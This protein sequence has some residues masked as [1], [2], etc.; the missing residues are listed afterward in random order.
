MAEKSHIFIRVYLG[1]LAVAHYCSWWSALCLFLLS[2]NRKP[3]IAG[4]DVLTNRESVCAA[5]H[6]R[7]SDERLQA[8]L[9]Y[10]RDLHWAL[11]PLG[12]DKRP[13]F[14]LLPTDPKTGKRTWKPYAKKRAGIGEIQRWFREGPD[15]NIG[16]ITGKV[17]GG[18]IIADFDAEPPEGLHMPVT[19][20]VVTARGFHAYFHYKRRLAGFKTAWGEVLGDGQ[21]AVLPPSFVKSKHCPDGHQYY[22]HEGLSPS[23]TEIA[24]LPLTYL[25]LQDTPATD[26]QVDR[27]SHHEAV[28]YT[29]E[30]SKKE[31]CYFLASSDGVSYQGNELGRACSSDECLRV[32]CPKLGI[33]DRAFEQIGSG[34]RCVL[35]GHEEKHPS[36]SLYRRAD[37]IV[38]YRDWHSPVK[39]Q[40]YYLPEVRASQAYRRATKLE[41]FEL[42]VWGLRLLWEA[43]MVTPARLPAHTVPTNLRPTVK[44]VYD[45]FLV[46]LGLRWLHTPGMA[47]P[48][49]WRFASAW[50]GVGERQVGK[51]IPELLRLKLI[52]VAGSHGS[53]HRKVTLFLLGDP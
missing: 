52:R 37:G 40:W 41:S 3:E 51:A 45:G 24:L 14:A 25:Q 27:E 48:F 29:P 16:V 21:Y 44:K 20:R 30:G 38:V 17:S 23:D 50:C 31:I 10:A 34:F 26:G 33:P 53:G 35:P 43:G 5:S 28:H 7:S 19:P 36:A 4:G 49:A 18:L 11:I 32:V 2:V 15:T 6:V 9:Y 1:L 39:D 42:A 12:P 22:W 13:N 8:A 46:L 47:A